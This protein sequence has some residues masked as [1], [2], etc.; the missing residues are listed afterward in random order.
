[1]KI[2]GYISLFTIFG[3]LLLNSCGVEPKKID[4]GNDHC[5]YCDMTV[6]DKTHSAE[7]VTKKGKA[8]MF[9]AIECMV[10]EINENKNE[11]KL[12]LILVADY[13]NPGELVDA[14]KTT[15]L[16]CEEIQSPMG[17][18]LSAFSNEQKAITTQEEFGGYIYTWEELKEKISE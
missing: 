13:A 7:Y 6:V 9:D 4:Y 1:M 15:F 18:F 10:R 16:I 12:A 17:E 11:D 2:L 3:M 5:S 14:R 8:Y